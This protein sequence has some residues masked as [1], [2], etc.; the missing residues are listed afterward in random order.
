MIGVEQ[1]SI[2]SVN[3]YLSKGANPNTTYYQSQR[4][5]HTMPVLSLAVKN[6]D[7][8]VVKSLLEHGAR[9]DELSW[10]KESALMFA[11]EKKN[12]VMVALLLK[13]KANARIVDRHCKS[14]LDRLSPDRD[15]T[16]V[17]IME[18]IQSTADSK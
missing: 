11:V 7:I 9:I 18:M 14:A 13:H 15:S 1:R 5:V 12:I 17:R 3:Y 2:N 6:E 8:D 4:Y 16:N 10:R